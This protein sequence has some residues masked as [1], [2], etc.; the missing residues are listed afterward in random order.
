MASGCAVIGY[1]G[2]GGKE[3]YRPEFCFPVTTGDIV[4]VAKT[5]E[6]VLE[7]FK[8]NPQYLQDRAFKAS[9]FIRKN[10]SPEIQKRDVLAFWNGILRQ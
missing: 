4:A 9:E 7:L 10:Y 2:R 1:H 6:K 5:V 8:K 3:F